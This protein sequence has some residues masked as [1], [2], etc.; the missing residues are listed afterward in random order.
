[1]QKLLT[2]ITF[3]VVFVTKSAFSTLPQTLRF[4]T[5]A[6]YPPFEFVDNK[7]QIQGFD[8]DMVN[9]LCKQMKVNCIFNNQPFDSLIPSLK[10]GKFDALASGLNITKERQ[11]Q[12]DFTVPYYKNTASFVT[13]SDKKFDISPTGLKGKTI[14]VQIGTTLK[15]FLSAIYPESQIKTYASQQ[16]A[17]LDLTSGR[18]D[19]V[20]SD[21]L[22]AL[23]WL[24][25]NNTKNQYAMIG[26]PV[27]D[28]QYFGNGYGIAVNKGNTELVS[29]LNEAL[30]QIKA[31]GEYKNIVRHYSEK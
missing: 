8:I 9:A 17:F 1:M 30:K 28:P 26:Q 20:F 12:V 10:L 4:G 14:G 19:L 27:S 23:S 21:T 24:E 22:M 3:L 16:D 25:A 13:L 29:A 5:E 15:S 6:T 2:L 31:N 11:Q 7:G 18:V